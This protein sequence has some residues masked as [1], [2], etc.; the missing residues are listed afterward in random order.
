MHTLTLVTANFQEVKRDVL[1]DIV[2]LSLLED[3]KI[4]KNKNPDNFIL[5]MYIEKLNGRINA[6]S[7]EVDAALFSIMYP[8]GQDS[9][10]FW[11]FE[12]CTEEL[13]DKYEN[14]TVDCI[15]LPNGKI[16]SIHNYPLY[17]KFVIQNGLVYKKHFGQLKRAKR[18]KQAKRMKAFPK[19][20]YRKLYK[21]LGD[22]AEEEYGMSYDEEHNG[23]GYSYNP[24][25]FWDWYSIGG[26]WSDLFLVK[27]DCEEYSIGEKSWMYQ[28]KEFECPK[29]Y[30]WAV[31]ARKKDIEWD[32]MHNW[33]VKC[34]TEQ[35][36]K[37]ERAF[38][39]GEYPDDWDIQIIGNKIVY[40][41]DILYIQNETL[42][43]H[44]KRRGYYDRYKYPKISGSYLNNGEFCDK[45]D[46]W[47][48]EK[49]PK[50][51]KKMLRKQNR[52]WRRKLDKFIDSLSD[53]TVLIGV[54]CHM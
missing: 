43:Q 8:Y 28:D 20:P 48:Y 30:K 19:F 14:A 50:K 4:E 44:L 35:F 6:F 22:F 27:E 11:D 34:A 18:N 12:D 13:Q 32:A 53:D 54:D 1:G 21:T 17:N 42:E 23:Y 7:R 38:Q 49:N 26:R 24:N 39:T 47:Q 40:F 52:I 29:G 15:K 2:I 25:A 16:V 33:R 3:C 46:Y 5:D 37:L 9:E 41:G 10:E 31:A 36:A 45:Y 51:H